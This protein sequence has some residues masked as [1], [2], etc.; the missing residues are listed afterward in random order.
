MKQ[1]ENTSKFENQLNVSIDVL[2]KYIKN[3]E[4]L[5]HEKHKIYQIGSFNFRTTYKIKVSKNTYSI[6]SETEIIKLLKPRDR[7]ILKQENFKILHI[8]AIQVAIKP[9]IRLGLN[10]SVCVCLKDARHNNFDNRI[11]HG[12]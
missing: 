12:A 9:L 4:M 10:K 6:G 2:E 11:K 7:E 5:K 8:G 3:W 1:K